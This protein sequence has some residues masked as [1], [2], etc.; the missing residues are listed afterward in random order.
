MTKK[1]KNDIRT[2]E[3]IDMYGRSQKSPDYRGKDKE[4]RRKN[5]D[6][7]NEKIGRPKVHEP[8][9]VRESMRNIDRKYKEKHAVRRQSRRVL[10]Y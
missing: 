4:Y 1:I 6:L 9:Y 10:G 5:K 8:E 2:P 7:E 3:N